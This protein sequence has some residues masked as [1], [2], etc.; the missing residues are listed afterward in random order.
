LCS[1]DS[2]ARTQLSSP[3]LKNTLLFFFPARESRALLPL[4]KNKT[5]SLFLTFV[6]APFARVEVGRAAVG[7]P[8]RL[9]LVDSRDGEATKRRLGV[10]VALLAAVRPHVRRNGHGGR[11]LGQALG[12]AFE[13]ERERRRLFGIIEKGGENESEF[14]S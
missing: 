9:A 3:S 8:D 4:Q 11:S 12:D 5:L 1:F 7:L 2:L 13:R 6:V 14:F 10:G